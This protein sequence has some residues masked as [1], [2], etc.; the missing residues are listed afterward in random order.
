MFICKKLS[1]WLLLFIAV[2]GGFYISPVSA[3]EDF[4]VTVGENKVFTEFNYYNTVFEFSTPPGDDVA[5]PIPINDRE[6]YVEGNIARVS[7]LAPPGYAGVLYANRGIQFEWN[8]GQY[9]WEQVK[10]WPV[11][12]TVDFSYKITASWIQGYGSANALVGSN[13]IGPWYDGIGHA[14][15]LSS[16]SRSATISRTYTM[17]VEEIEAKGKTIFLKAYCQA[18]S[19]PPTESGSN[20]HY[21]S[22]EVIINSIKIE[23]LPDLSV[24]MDYKRDL[25]DYKTKD[26]KT[27][28]G[29]DS[30][31]YTITVTN[32][33]SVDATG[34]VVND[35]LPLG[36]KLIS[37]DPQGVYDPT[38]GIL[39]VGNLAAGASAKFNLTAKVIQSGEIINKATLNE[40]S[41]L[42][43]NE[44]NVTFIARNPV[45]L[46]HGF[47]SG[48]GA[49]DALSKKLKQ[50]GI[51]HYKFDYSPG[52]QDPYFVAGNFNN[53]VNGYL[54]DDAYIGYQGKF[55]IVSHSMGALVTRFWME[56]NSANAGNV[57]QWIGIGPVNHGAAIADIMVDPT[58]AP[59]IYNQFNLTR[60]VNRLF[61]IIPI[62][63]DA[64][65]NMTTT[66]PQILA[67]NSDG[68]APGV[69]YRV[70]MGTNV[71][72][73][74]KMDTVAKIGDNYQ[75]TTAGDGIVANV[76]SMLIG[77]ATTD[78]FSVNHIDLPKN[79][80]VINKVIT[81]LKNN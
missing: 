4:V 80:D 25:K 28:Y 3:Q 19:V 58:V 39:N 60:K 62:D 15:G 36:L 8:L 17:T 71:R 11:N 70:I 56:G 7:L 44:A 81:Y 73:I 22:A 76:Q 65:R 77:S 23:F 18:H 64:V 30:V 63:S 52:F 55:D 51:R 29:A 35:L 24:S 75:F 74:P 46:V 45:I 31:I 20:T 26:D 2:V 12:V 79:R 54:R 59:E 69:I 38:T 66:D 68:I 21:S 43:N 5:L 49:W 61:N 10:N 41:N 48:P 50:E 13:L 14:S 78:Y 16:G 32:L 40:D 42:S 53:W 27:V 34:V 37:A 33:G 67:L 1:F 47:K 57:G 72:Q 9:T 6:S